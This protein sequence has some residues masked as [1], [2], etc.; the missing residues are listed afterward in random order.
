MVNENSFFFHHNGYQVLL[1][2]YV[3]DDME[4]SLNVRSVTVM[5]EDKTISLLCDEFAVSRLTN[6]YSS[7][8]PE[9]DPFQFSLSIVY[10]IFRFLLFLYFLLV[11]KKLTSHLSLIQ[12]GANLFK[13]PLICA[14]F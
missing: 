6:L 8:N 3:S 12:I 9:S 7:S 11:R 14:I 5:H 13:S 2:D 4:V 10:T 1:S